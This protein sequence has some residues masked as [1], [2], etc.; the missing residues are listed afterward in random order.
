M[1]YT[2]RALTLAALLLVGGTA[3]AAAP[4]Q[5]KLEIEQTVRNWA[6]A[7][8]RSDVQRYLAHYAADFIPPHGLS[9]DTWRAQRIARV[10]AGQRVIMLRDLA[11]IS[12]GTAAEAR[13][14][15]HY[16]GKQLLGTAQKRLLLVKRGS[17]WKIREEQVDDEREVARL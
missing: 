7:W 17:E 4:A 15:Q 13:F 8:E 12:A 9:L 2:H 14:T 6:L 5:E 10:R 3:Q 11:I 16:V 1:T